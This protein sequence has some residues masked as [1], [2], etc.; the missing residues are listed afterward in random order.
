MVNETLKNE[1]W[2]RIT[3]ESVTLGENSVTI[4][5]RCHLITTV[6]LR[7]VG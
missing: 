7:H 1:C 3:R 4:C 2:R 6:L 5:G